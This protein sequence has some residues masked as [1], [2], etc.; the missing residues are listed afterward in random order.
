MKNLEQ[1]RA[2]NALAYAES[3]AK[4]TNSDGG[5]VVKKLPALLMTNGLLAAAAFAYQ[6]QEDEVNRQRKAFAK[7]AG[8]P[9]TVQD[10]AKFEDNGFYTCFDFL[11]RHLE[12]DCIKLIPRGF[13]PKSSSGQK[14]A[15]LDVLLGFATGNEADSE[16][17]K[18]MTDEAL[19]WLAF[20]RRFIRKDSDSGGDDDSA[21]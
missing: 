18:L 1:I 3:D 20:A 4:K 19:A 16:T 8:K 9:P 17:I 5:N 12:D 14:L 13:V 7:R 21:D 10:E 2:A 15:Q 11:V 6:K